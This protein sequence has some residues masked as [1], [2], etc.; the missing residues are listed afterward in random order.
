MSIFPD[1]SQKNILKKVKKD[2]NIYAKSRR[3]VN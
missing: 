2:E 1:S 3:K